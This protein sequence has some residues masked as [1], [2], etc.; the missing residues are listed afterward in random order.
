[1]SVHDRRTSGRIHPASLY[2]GLALI[3]AGAVQFAV[4][5]PSKPWQDFV[6]WLAS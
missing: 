1:M 2:G 4:I 6:A 5:G 3:V